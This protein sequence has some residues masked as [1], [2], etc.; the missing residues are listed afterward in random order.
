MFEEIDARM[1]KEIKTLARASMKIKIV[2]P[3]Q[4]QLHCLDWR[5]HL[6]LSVHLQA[7][8]DLQAGVRRVWSPDRF[9]YSTPSGPD[10]EKESGHD[11]ISL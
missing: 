3:P 5:R 11:L 4:A 10:R 9:V 2:A 6:V 1:E 7:D 8:V